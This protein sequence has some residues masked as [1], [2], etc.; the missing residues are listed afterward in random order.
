MP[1]TA[2]ITSHQRI[3]SDKRPITRDQ[4]CKQPAF[5]AARWQR[6]V[7]L[8]RRRRRRQAAGGGGG[9]AG[10]VPSGISWPHLTVRRRRS[11]HVGVAWRERA[12]ELQQPNEPFQLAELSRPAASRRAAASHRAAAARR[13][14]AAAHRQLPQ[15]PAAN[16]APT[17]RLSQLSGT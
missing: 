4:Q 9:G 8:A 3:F 12:A 15:P 5:D 17:R 16:V 2:P 10:R 14:V 13:R 1:R 7:S 6:S 11:A